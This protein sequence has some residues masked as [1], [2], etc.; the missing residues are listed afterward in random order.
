M[1]YGL[2]RCN[3]KEEEMDNT[4][5]RIPVVICVDTSGSMTWTDDQEISRI[6]RV[7]KGIDVFYNEIRNNPTALKS[8]SLCVVGYCDKPFV[9]REFNDIK[10]ND[11]GADLK[12]KG[13]GKG[14]I[15][16]GAMES[17]RLL[18]ERKEFYRYNDINYKQPFLIL[19]SDGH[20]TASTKEIAKANLAKGQAQAL[21]LEGKDKLTVLP[22][23][24]GKNYETDKTAIKDLGGF[25]KVNNTI[26]IEKGGFFSFFRMLGRSISASSNGGNVNIQV[27]NNGKV[28]FPDFE[29]DD[30]D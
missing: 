28:T 26:D 24:V 23:Y 20:S 9:V 30:W 22:V 3:A 7:K 19:M 12:L 11:K 17:I 18:E 1:A 13:D 29:D 25:S 8:V 5:T 27:D 4:S 10:P 21:E 6:E 14:D 2:G 16:V 15:G